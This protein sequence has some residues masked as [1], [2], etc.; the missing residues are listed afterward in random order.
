VS[1]W[2]EQ[3]LGPVTGIIGGLAGIT[4]LLRYRR[5]ERQDRDEQRKISDRLVREEGAR[6]EREEQMR[7]QIDSAHGKIRVLDAR[8]DE[9]EKQMAEMSRDVKHTATTVDAIMIKLDRWIEG[10]R[11]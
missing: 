9:Q 7:K 5:M 8:Q 10:Q 4:A 11:K 3:I 1:G 6:S 2:Q